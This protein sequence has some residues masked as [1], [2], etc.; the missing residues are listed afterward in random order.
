[1]NLSELAPIFGVVGTIAGITG[2]VVKT[3]IGHL[4]ERLKELQDEVKGLEG[5]KK[6]LTSERD[7]AIQQKKVAEGSIAPLS[8]ET[9]NLKHR[10]GDLEKS[11]TDWK[12]R[13][14]KHKAEAEKYLKAGQAEYAQRKGLESK[15]KE[16]NVELVKLQTDAK[17]ATEVA[18]KRIKAAELAT[19]TALNLQKAAEGN[20]AK[21]R[22][23]RDNL[24]ATV[25]HLKKQIEEVL[26][27]DGRIWAAPV[28]PKVPPFV[29][30]SE[31]RT[32]II[33]VL[34]LK[35]GVGKTTITA[36]LAGYLATESGKRVLMIDLDHQRSLTQLLLT[37]ECR[38]AATLAGRTV[39]D[40]LTGK[41]TGADLH[42]VAEKV[43]GLDLCSVVTNSDP[44]TAKFGT[45]QNLDDIEMGLLSR[46]LVDP[47]AEDV[48]FLMR[49]ALHST[50]V[51]DEYDY[52]F[53]DCPPRL[54]TACINA[55]T[56]SDFILIPTQVETIAIRSVPHLLQRLKVLR[57][58]GILCHLQVLGIVANMV[59][60]NAQDKTSPEHKLLME[61]E[62]VAKNVW[63]Q[64]VKAFKNKLRD[65]GYYASAS[66]K[67]EECD[68]LSLA[69]TN[70]PIRE[71]FE[72]LVKE[73]EGR[74][75]ESIGVA[76]VPA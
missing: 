46:W 20:V 48:R 14:E 45:T 12:G 57:Q 35:G 69:V 22:Q 28:G 29:P 34:N 37:A 1:M 19:S 74:I 26:K 40:F 49:E 16:A 60:G 75:N 3:Y 64:A 68:K 55:L 66:K 50:T 71:Q 27:Q 21:L 13:A 76:G 51:R 44:E 56:A 11:A 5:D 38:K 70:N 39:Q 41:R 43:P 47:T 17:Q 23:E 67:L 53:I 61:F 52:V 2:W 42:A 62:G 58:A 36:N 30:L 63:G 31:R 72:P 6:I 73:I 10:V 4:K 65:S 32:P 15:L 9:H 7:T 59:S 24:T 54:T 25:T 33:S 8:I 18:E